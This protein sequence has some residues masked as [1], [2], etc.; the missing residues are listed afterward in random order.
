MDRIR[1]EIAA[2]R[3]HL[4]QRRQARDVA[5]VV[6]VL[7]L[8]QRRAL[9]R[10][11]RDDARRTIAQELRG[12]PLHRGTAAGPG[13]LGPRRTRRGGRGGGRGAVVKHLTGQRMPDE[14]ESQAGQVRPA[15]RATDDDVG[16]GL[17]EDGQLR[18]GLLTDDGLVQHHV[19]EHAAQRIPRVVGADGDLDG[20]RHRHAQ[21]PRGVGGLRQDRA[22]GLRQIRRRRVHRAAVDLHEHPAVRL[23]VVG[24]AHLPHLD[25]QA[26]ELRGE[27]QR[28]APLADAGLG[29]QVLD[30]VEH[31][32]V[33]LRHRR[34]RLVRTDRGNGL[35]LVVDAGGGAQRLPQ[36]AGA[37]Q[38]GGAPQAVDFADRLGDLDPALGGELLLDQ[39]GREDRRHLLRLQRLAGAGV[40]VRPPPGYPAT[41]AAFAIRLGGHEALCS[42]PRLPRRRP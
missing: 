3:V 33:R 25:A 31:V 18:R 8:G 17:A 40:Q 26:E 12:I 22:A 2:Q 9:R 4:Q 28:R 32:V 19:V 24:R 16:P 29:G 5:V 30:A 36:A 6:A 1:D 14:R 34:V 37:G 7:A 23:R 21:R 41:R 42:S 27:R 13:R 39:P 35:V 10:L 15:A 20:L 38:R 11:G